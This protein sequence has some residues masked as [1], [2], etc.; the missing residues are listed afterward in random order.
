MS[1]NNSFTKSQS[2]WVRKGSHQNVSW[3]QTA[4]L[5]S[6]VNNWP[7]SG[8]PDKTCKHGRFCISLKEVESFL[9]GGGVQFRVHPRGIFF[10]FH[11]SSVCSGAENP[12][13]FTIWSKDLHREHWPGL[14]RS[15]EAS[16][17]VAY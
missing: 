16:R 9:V 3:K 12:Q 11:F 7:R 15:A 5:R 8:P 10:H 1:C 14:R 17:K 2:W 13:Y 4:N 6:V